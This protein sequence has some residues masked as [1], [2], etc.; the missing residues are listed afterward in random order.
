MF[1]FLLHITQYIIVQSLLAKRQKKQRRIDSIFLLWASFRQMLTQTYSIQIQASQKAQNASG[2]TNQN[3]RVR[4]GR[5]LRDPT[6]TE[7]DECVLLLDMKELR[8][9]ER[10]TIYCGDQSPPIYGSA[11]SKASHN[12]RHILE[13]I[14]SE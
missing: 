12:R 10:R 7:A 11:S 6:S 5:V 14:N 8:E 2:Q 4:S 1:A 13:T 9:A 3:S